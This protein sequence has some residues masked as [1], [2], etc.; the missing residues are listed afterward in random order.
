MSFSKIVNINTDLSQSLSILK[1]IQ[2][3]FNQI[4]LK[5]MIGEYKNEMPNEKSKHL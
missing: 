2:R 1:C 4:I 5:C 3:I